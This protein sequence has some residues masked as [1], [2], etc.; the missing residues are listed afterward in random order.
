MISELFLL[1]S[2]SHRLASGLIL[3][4]CLKSLKQSHYIDV[5]EEYKIKLIQVM[6]LSVSNGEKELD[7]LLSMIRRPDE[8]LVLLF[9]LSTHAW[10]YRMLHVCLVLIVNCMFRLHLNLQLF[11]MA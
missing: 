8:K 1:E 9:A 5:K 6:T 11:D 4:C 2:S 7:D 3:A 10:C